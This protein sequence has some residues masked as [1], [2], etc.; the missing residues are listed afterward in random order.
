MRDVTYLNRGKAE[1]C[2]CLLDVKF[3]QDLLSV[4]FCL[5]KQLTF[6]VSFII[7]HKKNI[8]S[9]CISEEMEKLVNKLE[10]IGSRD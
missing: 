5:F 7:K 9:P 4:I 6:P 8:Y 1:I 10:N 2:C 3:H